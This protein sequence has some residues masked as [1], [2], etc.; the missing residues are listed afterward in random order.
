M[1]YVEIFSANLKLYLR[2]PS[3]TDTDLFVN[4]VAT[5]A[6][7]PLLLTWFNFNPSMDN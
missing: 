1:R 5:G 7:W 3:F 6:L 2:F 4:A